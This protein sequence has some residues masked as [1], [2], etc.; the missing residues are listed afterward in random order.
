[1]GKQRRPRQ[2]YHQ[3]SKSSKVIPPLNEQTTETQPILFAPPPNLFSGLEINVNDLNK[4][5]SE[6]YTV[7]SFKSESCNK[8]SK[9]DKTKLR[10]KMLLEKLDA[11]VTARKKRKRKSGPI[12]DPLPS[13]QEKVDSMLTKPKKKRK[14]TPKAAKRKQYFMQDVNLFKKLMY[15][16]EFKADPKKIVSE[17]IA[18][19]VECGK[20]LREIVIMRAILCFVY[21]LLGGVYA[22]FNDSL[23]ANRTGK[24]IG[25]WGVGVVR[26]E[27][28]VCTGANGLRGICYT[29]RQ[30]TSIGGYASGKC[31][32]NIGRCCIV[33]VSC[34]ATSSNN[35]TYFSNPT[36]PGTFSGA[37]ACTLTIQRC[38]PDI[39]QIR[40]DMLNFNLAQPNQNGICSDDAM[41]ITGAGTNVGR[42]CG[43]NTGQHIYLDFADG[44]DIIINI[45]TS[46][47]VTLGRQWNLRIAQIECNS[48]SRAPSG[49][50][51]YYGSV[52]GNVRSFNFGPSVIAGQTRQISN[53]NYGICVRAAPGFC[54]IQWTP[55]GNNAFLVSGSAQTGPQMGS[56]NCQ[57]DYIIIPN[58]LTNQMMQEDRFCGSSISAVTSQTRPFVLYAIT[59]GDEVSDVANIGF[60]FSYNQQ[61]CTNFL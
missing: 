50:L 9:K 17:H 57:T 30:C 15:N 26:F 40:I 61:Q 5:L 4:D 49:C 11:T 8:L 16:K 22:G 58:G 52:S 46:A 51:M 38:N 18:K 35:N 23:V 36:Y 33:Q 43:E 27:N 24:F 34:G 60:S 39:C 25:W 45:F 53:L 37:A 14:G 47:A 19:V 20:R 21:V 42:I 44:K 55:S 31:A 1:M 10:R 12:Q 56:A 28:S 41:V 2:K 6:T 48:P 3:I 54:T 32:R 7:K 13:L 29:R 59:N